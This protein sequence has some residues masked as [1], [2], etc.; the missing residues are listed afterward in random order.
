MEGPPAHFMTVLRVDATKGED[1]GLPIPPALAAEADAPYLAG[2]TV[3]DLVQAQQKAVVDALIG[4]QRP[5]RT[6]DLPRLDE[7]ALG[8]L[9]MHLMIE[10]ILAADLISVD[11]F[12]QP[13]VEVGKRLTRDYLAAG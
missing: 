8:A 10:T 12:D 2:H 11:P 3:G 7:R 9:M 1:N 6:I 4:A 5:V 13:A